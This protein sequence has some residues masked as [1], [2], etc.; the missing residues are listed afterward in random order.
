MRESYAISGSALPHPDG[1]LEMLSAEGG[2]MQGALCALLAPALK[3]R[4]KE[5]TPGQVLLA[6]VDDPS[7]RLDVE[8][9]CAL[10]GHDLL[11]TTEDENGVL[12]FYIRKSEKKTGGK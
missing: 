7:A 6:R 1:V 5:M 12:S 8:A 4:L 11:A 2:A 10:T 9:W 3:A